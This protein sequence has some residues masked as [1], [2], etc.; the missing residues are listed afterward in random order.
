MDTDY[1]V[2]PATYMSCQIVDALELQLMCSGS[3]ASR[4]SEHL[5]DQSD[6]TSDSFSLRLT[7]SPIDDESEFNNYGTSVSDNDDDSVACHLVRLG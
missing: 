5:D 3:M 2:L 7:P 1:Y 4:I 6:A